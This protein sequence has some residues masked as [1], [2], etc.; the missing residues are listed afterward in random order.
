[1]YPQTGTNRSRSR[2]IAARNA[3]TILLRSESGFP[4]SI[5]RIRVP[6]D[7]ATVGWG[8]GLSVNATSFANS[9]AM[10]L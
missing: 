8:F 6:S 9:M 1:M 10:R 3:L 7:I 5:Q 2:A 4:S